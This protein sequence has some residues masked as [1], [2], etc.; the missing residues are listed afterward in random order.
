MEVGQK[1]YLSAVHA[2]DEAYMPPSGEKR[3]LI[4][5]LRK[6]VPLRQST[7]LQIL[8]EAPYRGAASAYPLGNNPF[9]INWL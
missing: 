4:G 7:L 9:N 2:F 3:A 6:F 5:I 1:G 8:E